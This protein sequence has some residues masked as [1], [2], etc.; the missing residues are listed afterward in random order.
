LPA[1]TGLFT[2]RASELK[3]LLALA[4]RA[5][6]GG[7]PGTVVISAID[8]MGGVGKTA[9]AV[10]AA[11]RLSEHFPDGQLFL[12]LNG[13]AADVPP[14]EPADALAALLSGLGVSAQAI[15]ADT[16]ARA[17]LYRERL[18]GTRTLIL[19]DNAA[20]EAQVQP[21]LP[22]AETCLV[23]VTSRRRLKSLDDAWPLAVDLLPPEQAVELLSR[24]ARLEPGKADP[25]LLEHVAALCEYLPLAL[26]IAASL[27]RT[28]GPSWTLERVAE[29]LAAKPETKEPEL[30][31]FGDDA[32]NLSAVFDL[33][34]RALS[35]DRQGLYRRLALIP[36]P[37]VDAYAAAALLESDPQTAGGLLEALADHSLLTE[38]ARGRYRAHDLIRAHART[39]AA[40]VDAESEREAALDRL[41]VYY[42][43]TAQGASIPIA[44]Y[45]RPASDGPAPAHAPALAEQDAARA[46]LH[47]EYPNLDA[48]H[49]FARAHAPDT[50][51]LADHAVDLAAGLAE[52]L[53][54]DGIWA[55]AVELHEHAAQSAERS[56]RPAARAAAL[57][58]LGIARRLTGDMTGAE[59][60]LSRAL[61]IFDAAGHRIGQANALTELASVRHMIG[62]FNASSEVLSRALEIYRETGNHVGEAD[63]LTELG[64]VLR[65]TGDLPAADEA[66]SR[67]LEIYRETGNRAGEADALADLGGVRQYTGDL[68][69]AD[70]VLARALEIYREL[71]HRGGQA[72]ALTYLGIVRR[73]AKEL[74][75]AGD[76]LARALEI[77]R[78]LGSPF[79]AAAA[80][81]ELGDVRRLT[82]DL[83]AAGE[84]QREALEFYRETGHRGAEAWA[85]NHYAATVAATGDRP[86]ALALYQQALAA[87]RELDKP[88][89]EALSLE[90]I[91]DHHLAAGDPRR[92]AEHLNQA[93]EIYRNLGMLADAERVR[94]RLA[95]N[96]DAQHQV[97]T[98]D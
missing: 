83:A 56:G 16:D 73:Q 49:T 26:V 54:A 72:N 45:P 91:A 77:Y 28:G 47:A 67:A 53:R 57:T 69:G 95:E 27:V 43:H 44:R 98:E 76:A 38:T 14:R 4:E 79:G 31:A 7:E 32:R 13:Y 41:L 74:P 82:G 85:L 12:D 51:A 65:L 87:N 23:L 58:D 64:S 11:H 89:D 52:I 18:S 1:G 6:I 61:E 84:A 97:S 62:D 21:L 37:T 40:Q 88:D 8:G 55:H 2:G 70:D 75:E 9:L 48:A 15:P 86:Q 17:A 92:S 5:R 19:L 29:R 34:Y 68:P 93:L 96:T 63:A 22:A 66:L 94:A 39:L 71:G 36:G 10:H 20:N 78:E 60:A 80:L 3:A 46:W 42:A 25:A 35:A 90:G 81:T 33:S 50:P 24:A 59:D 30:A